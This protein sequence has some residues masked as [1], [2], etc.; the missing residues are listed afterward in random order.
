MRGPRIPWCLAALLP[1]LG[2]AIF[3]GASATGS[4][5]AL[6]LRVFKHEAVL[7]VWTRQGYGPF[8]LRHTYPL[9]ASSGLPGPKRKEGDRQVPEGFYVV[10]AFNPHSNFHLSLRVNYPNAADRVFADKE[11]PGSDIYI[12]GGAASIGCMPIGDEAIEEVYRLAE[13]SAKAQRAIPVHIFPARM[14][15]EGW[16]KFREVQAANR[17]E[18]ASFWAE[19][20]P[21]YDAF[22]KSRRLPRVEVTADGHYSV[23]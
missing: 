23:R 11:Q 10:D 5:P 1:V 22:E 6:Y 14:S 4:R 18:L 15:G 17:P 13:E 20:Q 12:H 8:T 2:L 21:A 19:L 7:E 16:E 3:L 9:T